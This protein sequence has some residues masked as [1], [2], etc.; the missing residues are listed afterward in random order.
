MFRLHNESVSKAAMGLASEQIC[1]SKSLLFC[2]KPP[3]QAQMLLG[4]LR[5]TSDFLFLCFSLP[6]NPSGTKG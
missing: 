3:S 2:L 4:G 6:L 5:F 1:A